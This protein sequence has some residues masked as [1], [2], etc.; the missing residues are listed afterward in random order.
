MIT[1]LSGGTGTPKLLQGL[2]KE[3]DPKDINVIVNTLENNYFSGVYVSA[4]IDTVLYTLS[5]L[6]NEE[7]WYGQKNDTFTTHNQLKKLGYEEILKIGDKD[8]AL[9]IQKTELLKKHTLTQATD[10][11]RKKLNIKSKVLPM[12]DEQ[13]NITINTT[14]GLLTFHEYLIEKQTKPEIIEIKYNTVKPAPSIIK[15]I[16][17]STQI[18]IGPSNPITSILPIISMKNVE[19]TLTKKHVTC[20]SPLKDDT[21][22]SGPTAK[23]MK[24]KGYSPTNIGIA[25]IYKN[26]V[27]KYIINNND[28]KHKQILEEIIP[29]V[30]IMDI[31]LNSIHNKQKIAKNVLNF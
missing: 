25:T 18:I 30:E 15:T 26:I 23:F 11:Q 20:I 9:K 6:I 14:D 12:S 16:E 1:V 3:T 31:E 7:T 4:D 27:D 17:N 5:G 19:K 21:P 2:I 22:F 10:I 29:K 24:A 28:E 8:R 13:S